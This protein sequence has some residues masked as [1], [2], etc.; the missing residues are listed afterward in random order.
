MSTM[1]K[2]DGDDCKNNDFNYDNKKIY[3]IGM[4]IG[5]NTLEHLCEECIPDYLDDYGI[6]YKI[7]EWGQIVE[8]DKE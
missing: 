5:D 1:Y 7:N 4:E 8:K 3:S 2:C 6:E